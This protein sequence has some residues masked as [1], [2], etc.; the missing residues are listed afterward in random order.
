[1]LPATAPGGP[2]V[3]NP[4]NPPAITAKITFDLIKRHKNF[5]VFN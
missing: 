4:P 5:I 3:N 2:R 1:M